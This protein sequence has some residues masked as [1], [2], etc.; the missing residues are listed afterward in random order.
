[1]LVL[2][3]GCFPCARKDSL[4]EDLFADDATDCERSHAALTYSEAGT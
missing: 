4:E 3:C 1:M 2:R